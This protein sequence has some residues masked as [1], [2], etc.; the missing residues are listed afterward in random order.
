[1]SHIAGG[2][3]IRWVATK[4][5]C[6]DSNLNHHVSLKLIS[7]Y[8]PI[9]GGRP[10]CCLWTQRLCVNDE[11]WFT[12]QWI[13]RYFNFFW[14][15]LYEMNFNFWTTQIITQSF[16]FVGHLFLLRYRCFATTRVVFFSF[17]IAL[18]IVCKERWTALRCV[19]LF[20][21]RSFWEN[22]LLITL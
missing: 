13:L 12:T 18:A 8:L 14:R 20:R 3:S 9:T 1:M 21:R 22:I 19:D 4:C 7:R 17:L 10:V 16:H 6:L 11:E 2:H 15:T 5:L